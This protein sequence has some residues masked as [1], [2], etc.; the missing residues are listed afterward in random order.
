MALIQLEDVTTYGPLWQVDPIADTSRDDTNFIGANKQLAQLSLNIKY[1]MLWYDKE[2]AICTVKGLVIIHVLSRSVDEHPNSILHGRIPRARYQMEAVD[3]V[4]GFVQI[5][6]IPS[7][8]IGYLMN[9]LARLVLGIGV[10]SRM[11]AWLEWR[12]SRSGKNPV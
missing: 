2:I 4:N 10:E 9:L 8:L 5:E 11:L 7:Q 1:A 6:R 12:M 3:P